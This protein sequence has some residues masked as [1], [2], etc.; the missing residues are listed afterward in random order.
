MSYDVASP[1]KWTGKYLVTIESV[2]PLP[3]GEIVYCFIDYG[4]DFRIFTSK[5]YLGVVEF[6]F[7]GVHR[8]KFS[9]LD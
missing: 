3:K 7:V 9:V 4:E 8:S 1:G 2:G 6:K 5:E